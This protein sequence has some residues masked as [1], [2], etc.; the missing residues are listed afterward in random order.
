MA[1]TSNLSSYLKDLANAIREKKGTEAQIPAANFDTEILS[2]ETGIDTSDATAVADDIINPK[3][4]YVNGEKIIGSIMP[5]YE[6]IIEET[7]TNN[8]FDDTYRTNT[9]TY[10]TSTTDGKYVIVGRYTTVN[11][12]KLNNNVYE[13]VISNISIRT[14][15]KFSSY[16]M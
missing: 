2:I 3:T 16:W 9:S 6:D 14:I 11:I 8:E 13:Q 15:F 1:D 4:A 7:Y 10:R 5:T 12:Y